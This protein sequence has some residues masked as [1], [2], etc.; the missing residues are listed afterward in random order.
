M[1]GIKT[2][3]MPAATSSTA[4]E[5]MARQAAAGAVVVVVVVTG[6]VIG[7]LQQGIPY[8]VANGC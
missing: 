7:G 8:V 5:A 3:A 6:R 1:S 2:A 4:R